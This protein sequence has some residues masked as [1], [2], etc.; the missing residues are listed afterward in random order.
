M[1]VL[2]LGFMNDLR[3]SAFLIVCI[4]CLLI[5]SIKVYIPNKE[6]QS[7]GTSVALVSLTLCSCILLIMILMSI[8]DDFYYFTHGEYSTFGN[9]QRHAIIT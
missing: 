7:T 3:L 1:G 5:F 4:I 8:P 6:S 9:T 2:R